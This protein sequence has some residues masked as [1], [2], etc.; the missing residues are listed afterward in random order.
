MADIAAW[1]DDSYVIPG[2]PG[3]GTGDQSDNPPAGAAS[4]CG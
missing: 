4:G 3:A 1:A 2:D